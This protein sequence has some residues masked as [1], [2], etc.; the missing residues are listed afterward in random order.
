MPQI[1]NNILLKHSILLFQRKWKKSL[2]QLVPS[3][4]LSFL[5]AQIEYITFQNV[6]G[7]NYI[8]IYF[9]LSVILVLIISVVIYFRESTIELKAFSYL[10]LI[11]FKKRD[12]SGIIFF[13]WLISFSIGYIVAILLFFLFNSQHNLFSE[14]NKLWDIISHSFMMNLL[15]LVGVVLSILNFNPNK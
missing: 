2:L 13:K 8:W 1:L 4:M 9:L 15:L 3:V 10:L 12:V 11:G 14:S 6:E 7:K 5:F